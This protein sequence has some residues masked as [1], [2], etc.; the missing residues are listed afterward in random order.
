MKENTKRGLIVGIDHYEFQEELRGCARDA[1]NLD[2]VL[3][4][5]ENG[6]GNFDC[7]LLTSLSNKTVTR[8]AL[9]DGIHE[10]FETDA[11][12]VLFY[13][14]GHCVFDE[15]SSTGFFVTQDAETPED[16]VSFEHLMKCAN[17]AYPNIKSTVIIVDGCNSGGLGDSIF[18]NNSVASSSVATGVT[19]LT[20]TGRKGSASESSTDGGLFS[21]IMIDALHG[22]AAD[23]L[24]RIT[25]A[26]VYAHI[27][28]MLGNW[29]Q[30]PVYKANVSSF[31]TLRKCNER[32][33]IDTLK[34]LPA[35]FPEPDYSFP[36][37]PSF[38]PDRKNIPEH[39]R[40]TPHNLENETIFAQLQACNRQGLVVPVD[41]PHMYDAAIKSTGCRLTELGKHYRRL[42][43]VGKLHY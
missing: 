8:R 34:A 23:L 27:D 22:S 29:G 32:I 4:H 36:L 2:S 43:E 42:S 28:R 24:G 41:V 19:V 5:H 25:P 33:S 9:L 11:D 18:S 14:A 35:L 12:C 1:A 21:S 26:S 39:L 15:Q 31:V 7:R 40:N 16:G 30:R 37:N 38:E 17:N 20:A 10:L 13:F 3:S 6:S